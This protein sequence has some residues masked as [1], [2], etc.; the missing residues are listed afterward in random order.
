MHILVNRIHQNISDTNLHAK[1]L[2]FFNENRKKGNNAS[3]WE[4]F[5]KNDD[6][7]AAGISDDRYSEIKKDL[8]KGDYED[9]I[10]DHLYRTQQGQPM[11]GVRVSIC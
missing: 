10:G 8:K 11:D 9:V 6:R 3:G 2:T 1:L 4:S 7:K 5:R